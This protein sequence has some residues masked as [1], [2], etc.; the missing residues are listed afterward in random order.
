MSSPPRRSLRLGTPG[1]PLALAQASRIAQPPA[2]LTGA[3]GHGEALAR[4]L[5]QK[6]LLQGG[7]ALRQH[8]QSSLMTQSSL[9]TATKNGGIR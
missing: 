7:A 6:L 8:C 5:A 9:L 3:A 1:S 2:L 4:R